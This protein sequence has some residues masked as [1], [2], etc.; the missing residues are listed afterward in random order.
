MEMSSDLQN[1]IVNVLQEDNTIVFIMSHTGKY[2]SLLG[3][4]NRSLYSDGSVLIGKSYPDVLVKEK[5]DY[6]KS[7]LEEVIRTESPLEVEYELSATDFLEVMTE[8]PSTVQKFR[9]NLYPLEIDPDEVEHK[10]IWVVHNITKT[11]NRS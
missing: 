7:L 5:A 2:L 3:G 4:S 10:V 9:G 8:G 1:E 11:K 6:F